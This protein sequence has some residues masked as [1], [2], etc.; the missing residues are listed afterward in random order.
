MKGGDNIMAEELQTKEFDN[1]DVLLTSFVNL[2]NN[3]S[4]EIGVTLNIGGALITGLLIGY[5]SYLKGISEMLKGHGPGADAFSA[6]FE[7]VL[8]SRKKHLE[9]EE[10]MPL[11][12]Y[13]HLKNTKLTD[14]HGNIQELGYWR[15]KLTSVDGFILG[16]K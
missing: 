10:E 15:G 9:T 7:Y 13:I 14:V 4:L 8:E 1:K 5:D 6:Q 16:N 12:N 2:A 11:P 3:I